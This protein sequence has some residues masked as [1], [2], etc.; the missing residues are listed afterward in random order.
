MNNV[1]GGKSLGT[2]PIL[3]LDGPRAEIRLQRPQLH[4][5]LQPE[6][7]EMLERLFE[8]IDHAPGIRVCIFASSGKTFSAGFDIGSIGVTSIDDPHGY[9]A[10]PL[11]FERMVNRLEQLRVPTIAAIQGGVYGGAADLALACDFRVGVKTT[12]LRVPAAVLGV[13]YYASGLQR[14][15]NRLSLGAAKRVFLLAETLDAQELHRIGYLDEVVAADQLEATV[16]RYA[17]Q[18]SALAPLAV[19]GMKRALNEASRCELNLEATGLAIDKAMRSA[20]LKI[21]LAAW[22]KR[23]SPA[24]T[25][26]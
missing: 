3:T 20:D 25:G 13:H 23:E 10:A 18:L 12:E 11:V 15:A 6:D 24:F 2:Q 17:E 1:Q 9:H 19:A 4:N 5:R 26:E 16:N 21:G 14:F 7:L 22:T 8:E